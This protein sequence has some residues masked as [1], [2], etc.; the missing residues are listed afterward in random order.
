VSPLVRSSICTQSLPPAHALTALVDAG[1]H[2]EHARVV[3]ER[4][5]V[6][7]GG[8]QC[9]CFGR[10]MVQ[11]PRVLNPNTL[12]LGALNAAVPTDIRSE[13]LAAILD[14]MQ[15]PR[16][17]LV[18]SPTGCGKTLA[19]GGLLRSGIA[20]SPT[21]TRRDVH[22]PMIGVA[23]T[24]AEVRAMMAACQNR[25]YDCYLYSDKDALSALARDH[26][27]LTRAA[28]FTTYHSLVGVIRQLSGSA[29]TVQDEL[30]E[31]ARSVTAATVLHLFDRLVTS[32]IT[33]M[34][35]ET[36]SIGMFVVDEC[37]RVI[38][39]VASGSLCN[40]GLVYSTLRYFIEGPYTNAAV[41]MSANAGDS[42]MRLIRRSECAYAVYWHVAPH[43][44]RRAVMHSVIQSFAAAVARA[45]TEAI[46]EGTTVL[47]F[48]DSKRLLLH[49]CEMIGFESN[50][51]DRVLSISS[52]TGRPVVARLAEGNFIDLKDRVLAGATGILSAAVS[53][54]KDAN[55]RINRVFVV[56]TQICAVQDLQQM[57]ARLREPDS[58]AYECH[59]H[60][61]I[62]DSDSDQ[63]NDENEPDYVS[64][65]SVHRYYTH[66]LRKFLRD[67][68]VTGTV[69][70]RGNMQPVPIDISSVVGPIR[71]C[72]AE[73]YNT[74]IAT[75]LLGVAYINYLQLEDDTYGALIESLCD[76]NGGAHYR[77]AAH[78][79]FESMGY[80]VETAGV[81]VPIL[82]GLEARIFRE[83]IKLCLRRKLATD[84]EERRS[85]IFR[86]I[87][88]AYTGA[89]EQ[90]PDADEVVMEAR[91]ELSRRV[92]AAL[93]WSGLPSDEE[94]ARSMVRSVSARFS[95][96]IEASLSWL[97]VLECVYSQRA[98]AEAVRVR[99]LQGLAFFLDPMLTKTEALVQILDAVHRAAC[100][101]TAG[102][103]AACAAAKDGPLSSAT[104]SI[105]TRVTR[106]D[107]VDSPAICAFIDQHLRSDD[108]LYFRRILGLR[109]PHFFSWKDFLQLYN[110]VLV[111]STGIGW[112]ARFVNGHVRLGINPGSAA[113]VRFYVLA[114]KSRASMLAHDT[115]APRPASDDHAASIS[116]LDA[117]LG[118]FAPL[119]G[120]TEVFFGGRGEGETRFPLRKI[121]I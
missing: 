80:T 85:E 39:L 29:S 17:I 121:I 40:P 105:P 15:A 68:H 37:E 69:A 3:V 71:R 10:A 25:G 75:G 13:E 21:F 11:E 44:P 91:S 20:D 89:D 36:V 73:R 60:V 116:Q 28:V 63:A 54:F 47:L 45:V 108:S 27:L 56:G 102:T 42:S 26:V 55:C 22:I 61:I 81:D 107:A 24:I 38:S 77:A 43:R 59:V 118:P 4:G 65:E 92:C 109:A 48:V 103:C 83:F 115:F 117:R 87:R 101:C 100:T 112:N 9:F 34:C 96:D 67:L 16:T 86:A 64:E 7:G 78:T 76:Y 114:M 74:C 41:F 104:I 106:N 12:H 14:S 70:R 50:C 46:R 99:G 113:R 6:T 2:E 119:D 18:I 79:D 88:Q 111:D 82:V 110:K 53:L 35:F 93:G 84:E 72:I 66:H 120:T 98:Y 8:S 97:Y 51:A 23:S 57:A 32:H 49:L 30:A 94:D 33:L 62:S 5:T 19:L 1:I 95:E 52:P 31:R 58:G 90:R